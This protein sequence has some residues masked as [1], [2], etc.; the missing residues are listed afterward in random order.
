LDRFHKTKPPPH[1]GGYER[2]SF[3]TGSKR[4]TAELVHE[5][6]TPILCSF[7]LL[8]VFLAP[9]PLFAQGTNQ[10]T[11]VTPSPSTNVLTSIAFGNGRFVAVGYY[12]TIV[13]SSDGADWDIRTAGTNSWLSGSEPGRDEY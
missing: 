2:P 6:W 7:A 8:S 12:G 4:E 3:Q 1:L 11:V 10:W 9:N 5:Q 13:T